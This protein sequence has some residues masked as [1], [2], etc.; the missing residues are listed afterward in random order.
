M[1][2][3][4][5]NVDTSKSKG[6]CSGVKKTE[7]VKDAVVKSKSS[8]AEYSMSMNIAAKSG[9]VKFSRVTVIVGISEL[10]I[11]SNYLK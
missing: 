1:V 7:K 3:K 9:N 6:K 11:S 4:G 5:K 10:G 8:G 2:Y